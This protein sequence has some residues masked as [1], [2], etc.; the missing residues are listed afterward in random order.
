MILVASS[1]WT[2]GGA[3]AG[4]FC[5]CSNMAMTP[6]VPRAS[7]NWRAGKIHRESEHWD[8]ATESQAKGSRQDERWH[9][10]ACGG[11]YWS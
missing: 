7:S 8:A 11:V 3:L 2:S 1:F 6:I 4:T 9:S 5:F 10:G